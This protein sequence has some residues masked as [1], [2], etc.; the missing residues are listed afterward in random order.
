MRTI[1]VL[2][3][4]TVLITGCTEQKS[5]SPQVVATSGVFMAEPEPEPLPKTGNQNADRALRENDVANPEFAAGGGKDTADPKGGEG[6]REKA[7]NGA[8]GSSTS[9]A[10]TSGG[11]TDPG[12]PAG[13]R[14]ERND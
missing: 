11:N 6:G 4:V 2:G 3:V 8:G 14:M 12:D 7:E 13:G 5:S 10:T 1:V 9:G